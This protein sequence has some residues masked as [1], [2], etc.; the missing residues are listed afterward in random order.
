[1]DH[2]ER[3]RLGKVDGPKLVEVLRA[4]LGPGFTVSTG[5]T[6]GSTIHVFKDKALVAS[7]HWNDSAWQM[8]VVQPN[9]FCIDD[10]EHATD[11]LENCV[12]GAKETRKRWAI[13]LRS[14]SENTWKSYKGAHAAHYFRMYRNDVPTKK[15]KVSKD[16]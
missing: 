11:E 3:S 2:P 13:F 14:R 9:V 1:M 15:K 7:F 8:F 6:A 12:R 4:R 16:A 5:K 10:A